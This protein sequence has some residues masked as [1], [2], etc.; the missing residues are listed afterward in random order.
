M[1]NQ[2]KHAI[3]V[4]T[5]TVPAIARTLGYAGLIP[6][7]GLALGL[8]LAPEQYLTDIHNALL[9][10]GAV[11]LSFMGAIH[12]GAAI[13]LKNDKQKF[14]LSISVIPPLIA[15]IAILLP[16]NY[17]YAVLIVAFSVLCFFDSQMTKQGGL[18]DWYP[19]LRVPLTTIVVAA[20][21]TSLLATTIR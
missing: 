20:L 12:W 7:I 16:L 8:W 5:S 3:E 17:A 14:H 15:W 11:I 6:F 4:N 9:S 2:N 21:I 1:I 13:D 10:Y 19:L 18:P